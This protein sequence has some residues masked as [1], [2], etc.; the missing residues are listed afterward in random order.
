PKTRLHFCNLSGDAGVYDSMRWLIFAVLTTLVPAWGCKC[1]G[2]AS[3]C[4]EM[5]SSSVIFVAEGIVDSGERW[6]TGPAKV[7]I[8]E[9]LQNVPAGQKEA[10][11][12][13]MAGTSCYFRL[14]AGE[15]YVIITSGPNYSVGV[16]SSSFHLKGNE[17]I[18]EAMRD[19]LKGGKSRLV[20]TVGK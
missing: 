7:A 17:H 11:V 8:I 1:M 4:S 15:R 19:R 10:M 3:P 18:L 2:E 6:G 9:A 20:G 16:C 5:G 13:T 12:A 14:K